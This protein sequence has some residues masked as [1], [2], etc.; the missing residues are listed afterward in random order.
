L[1]RCRFDD[2]QACRDRCGTLLLILAFIGALSVLAIKDWPSSSLVD[3]LYA[4]GNRGFRKAAGAA[5]LLDWM[6]AR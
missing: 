3:L 5:D 1:Q 4:W 6:R 2:R